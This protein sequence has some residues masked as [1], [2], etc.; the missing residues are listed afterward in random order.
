MA[1]KEYVV[2]DGVR[3]QKDKVPAWAKQTRAENAPVATTRAL[4]PK[5]EAEAKVEA[6][7][8]GASSDKAETK[9]K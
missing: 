1:E 8:A 3:F 9:E 2:I 6:K 5:V 7:T 4:T